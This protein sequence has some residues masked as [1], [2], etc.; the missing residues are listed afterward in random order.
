MTNSLSTLNERISERVGQ[1][2]VD[3]LPKEEWQKLI[4]AEM[5]KFK[6]EKA[7]KIIREM[8]QDAYRQQ[9]LASLDKFC[10]TSEW[11]QVSNTYTNEELKKFITASSSE[12][13]AG[14][15]AP[16][17]QQALSDLRIRLGY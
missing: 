15:L 6:T 16:F 10:T 4:D 5:H 9:A 2:L 14:M 12:I 7:V 8:L 1:E 17:M 11:D 3:L 13:F